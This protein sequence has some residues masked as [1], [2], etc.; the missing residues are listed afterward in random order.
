MTLLFSVIV[1]THNRSNMLKGCLESLCR[2]TL[3]KSKYE[4]IVVDNNS[5]DD[6]RQVTERFLGQGNVRYVSEMQL[7]LSHARNR[8]VREALGRYVA[9]IDDDA[10]AAVNWLEDAEGVIEALQSRLDVLGGPCY[11]F[12]T[13]PKPDWFDGKYETRSFGKLPKYLNNHEYISGSN[14]VWNK[15]SLLNIDGFDL[16]TGV[17]GNQ[18]RMGEETN[19]LQKL[20]LIRDDAK[21][22]FSPDLVIYHLVPTHKM[23]IRY[24]LKRKFAMGQYVA[25][26]MRLFG[27]SERFY[28][29]IRLSIK[30]LR[31]SFGALLR[32]RSYP[33]WQNWVV[34]E[35][36]QISSQMGVIFGLVGLQLEL[37]QMS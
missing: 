5:T 21:V 28:E 25:Y 26:Q 12:Y 31:A 19:A 2:Q 22:Y 8:G 11:P 32:Y 10:R 4:V 17:I 7:G 23:T 24:R 9:Y 3:D 35:G 14:M 29:V 20:R 18:L 16:N 33:R 30:T 37:S 15:E 13:S 6:T 34:E 1:C 27:F 36:G